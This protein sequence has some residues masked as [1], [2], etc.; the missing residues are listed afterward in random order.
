MN[1]KDEEGQ[2]E[3]THSVE[4]FISPQVNPEMES[5]HKEITEGE[6]TK[7]PIH[8]DEGLGNMQK[9]GK[10]DGAGGHQLDGEGEDLATNESP[11]NSE[12]SKSKDEEG[13][14]EVTLSVESFISPQVNPEMESLQEEITEGEDTKQPIH[15]DEGLGNMQ[16]EGKGDGAG[17][18]QLDGEGEDLATNESPENGEISKKR[19]CS[20]KKE[21]HERSAE[22]HSGEGDSPCL[23]KKETRPPSVKTQDTHH[24]KFILIGASF[25]AVLAVVV[26]WFLRPEPPP[27]QKEF[28][29]LDVFRHEMDKVQSSFPS[30][31][32]ELWR[33]SKIHLQ[34]HLQMSRPSEPVSLILTSGRGAE[35]T[36]GCLAQR[37]AAA[38]STSLNTSALDIDGT[39]KMAQD[40]DQV[41]LDIDRALR[42]A[43]DA[44][45]QAAVIHRFEELPPGSTLIFYRYCD[46]EN[47]AYKNVFLAFTVLLEEELEVLP[48][49]SLGMVEEIVQEYLK[50]KFVSSHRTAM[51]NQMD[52]DKLSGLWSRISH[53]ILPVAAEQ[54][55]ELHGCGG[56]G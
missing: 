52:V 48:N 34:R 39:S 10:G 30:Q 15:N 55:I 6:D 43:F 4:S 36:L 22:E 54:K 23:D 16:K 14:D 18:H 53:L 45:K 37:L 5:L 42:E 19:R 8:N 9:E 25:V 11:E 12:I 2:D 33:R 35:K 49:V 27:V 32:K 56:S 17:G 41:K 31:H 7:Q 21:E 47:A 20:I 28:N 51:F 44:G 29:L 13:Q 3:V 26:C 40:S 50:E 38:F 46:H 24:K 1:G